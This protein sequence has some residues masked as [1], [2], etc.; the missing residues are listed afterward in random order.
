MDHRIP[1]P[2]HRDDSL[3]GPTMSE[4]TSM[5]QPVSRPIHLPAVLSDLF[6]VPRSETRRRIALGRVKVNGQVV[7]DLDID[8]DELTG[9]DVQIEMENHQPADGIVSILRAEQE[10]IRRGQ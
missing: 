7:T 5:G 1:R 6:H 9:D 4:P 3:K 2:H 10:A 8:P